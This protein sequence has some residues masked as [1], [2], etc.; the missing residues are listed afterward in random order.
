MPEL[1]TCLCVSGMPPYDRLTAIYQAAAEL[2]GDS[3]LPDSLC[4]AGVP[5]LARLSY[6]YAAFRVIAA[7]NSLPSQECIE[8]EQF[9][10]QVARIYQAARIYA[11]DSSLAEWTCV[12]GRPIWQQWLEIYRA[13]YVAAGSPAELTSPYC[14]SP[15]PSLQILT[16][17]FCALTAACQT[18]ELLSATINSNILTL[19]FSERVTGSVG[20]SLDIE[21]GAVGLTYT[22]GQ[23]TDTL[24]YTSAS[25]ANP[26]D[27]V[28]LSYAPGNVGSGNCPLEEFA[29]FL[30][31]NETGS[32][33]T[34]LRPGGAFTYFRPDGTSI[35]IR[36]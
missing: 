8:G 36:P 2:S 6:I 11:G 30:V 34:Y 16:D 19:V 35:Y 3:S 18:P 14:L 21:G 15:Q 25:A 4:V 23:G 10:D 24:V 5:P 20:F 1:P 17:V 12:R 7:D 31:T 29:D 27:D 28:L 33:F 13:L 22:S 32:E 26:G 9:S